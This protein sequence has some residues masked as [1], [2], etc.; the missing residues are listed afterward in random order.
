MVLEMIIDSKEATLKS[1][2]KLLIIGAF[3]ATLGVIIAAWVFPQ[4]ASMVMVFITVLGMAY[5]MH[6]VI[7]KEE[8]YDEESDHEP[9]DILVH[10]G[11]TLIIFMILFFGMLIAYTF[12]YAVLPW[13]SSIESG[14]FANLDIRTVFEAQNDT[15]KRI[16]GHA[17]TGAASAEAEWFTIILLNNLSVL[18][19]SFLFGFF[20]GY[21]GIFVLSWNASV[22]AAAAGTT[23]KRALAEGIAWPEKV[24]VFFASWLAYMPHGVFEMLGFF[25]GAL[26]A[27]ILGAGIARK[28]WREPDKLARVLTDFVIFSFL[29]AFIIFFAAIIEVW[30]TPALVL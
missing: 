7:L 9:H 29:S 15:V 21:G 14:I 8:E 1:W 20:Y 23:F 6:E 16:T 27:G 10:H 24:W 3:Y 5:L 17:F 13:T 25:V 4:H 2:W 12:W 11:Q 18:L 26:A 30:I 19:F 28:V 22:I